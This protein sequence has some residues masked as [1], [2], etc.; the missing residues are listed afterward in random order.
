MEAPCF[1]YMIF[2]ICAQFRVLMLL[3]LYDAAALLVFLAVVS[4]DRAAGEGN[5]APRKARNLQS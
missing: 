4:F 2:L 3:W 5:E 1:I